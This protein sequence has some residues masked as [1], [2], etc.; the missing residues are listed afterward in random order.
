MKKKLI[1]VMLCL[2]MS[3][4]LLAGCSSAAGTAQTT[5]DS[6]ATEITKAIES[7]AA[8]ESAAAAEG[9]TAKPKSDLKYAVVLHALNSSF[10]AKIQAGAEAAGKALGVKVDVMAPTTANNLAE[11]VSMIETCIASG[12]DGIATVIWDPDGFNDVLKKAADA[13]IPVISL[14]QNSG[15]DD[16]TV[17]V[18]QDLEESGYMLGKY[19]FGTVMGGEG[20]YIIA[21]CSPADVALIAREDGIKRAAKEFPGI[22]FV[23][24]IDITTDLTTAVGV[25]ENAYLANPDVKAFLGVDV[26]SEAI[27]TYIQTNGLNGKVFGAGYDL[28]EGTL[29]HVKDNAMQLTIGQNPFL[30]GYYPVI[31]LFTDSQYGYAP[32]NMSTGAF[33]V[34]KDNV[35]DVAPE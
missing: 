15:K 14:N 24:E 13:G 10:Y 25:I 6:A 5:Q 3:I 22:E 17:F 19:M 30:Q 33:L 12:Y 27:G 29:Q 9:T 8:T 7:A 23:Q 35:A 16:G 26:F 21:S 2:V 31:Q 1:S 28:T 4:G 20:K 32:L 11:Q 18:G 34:T